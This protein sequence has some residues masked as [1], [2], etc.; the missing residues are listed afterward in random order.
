MLRSGQIVFLCVLALL[1]LGVVMV[2][3]AG[4][5]VDPREAV[6]VKSIL[7]SRSTVYMALAVAAMT[8]CALLPIRRLVPRAW[9]VSPDAVRLDTSP[10]GLLV[11]GEFARNLL[12]TIRELWPMWVIVCALLAVLAMVYIPG[13]GRTVNGSSRWISL[14]APGLESIQP[15]EL[16]KWALVGVLAWYGA[17]NM[18]RL[19]KFWRGLLPGLCAAGAVAAF[20]VVED[21]GTGVLLGLVTC[22]VLVAAGARVWHLAV[23]APLPLTMVGLAISTSQYRRERLLAFMNPYADADGIGYHMIQSMVAVANGNLAGRGLG[24][25]L[26]KFGY[27]P[28]DRTDFLFAVI[29]EELGVA[30]A[31]MV[32]ALYGLMFYACW[33]IIRREQA[34]MLKL[35]GLGVLATVAIQAIIN[36]A[37]VTGL[38]PT[39]GIALPLLSSGGTGWILTAASLG[40]IVAMDRTQDGWAAPVVVDS[41][42]AD[43]AAEPETDT[44]EVEPAPIDAPSD[45]TRFAPPAL[46]AAAIPVALAAA[47]ADDDRLSRMA[48]DDDGEQ[49]LL[50]VPSTETAPQRADDDDDNDDEWTESDD[51]RVL[52]AN[53]GDADTS[54][55]GHDGGPAGA[56]SEI[57][58]RAADSHALNERAG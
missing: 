2:N 11:S 13:L 34:A 17:T 37:V 25:G 23:L 31:F 28:E 43:L 16:A 45:E 38:G 6:T 3:S 1:T 18:H 24:H 53:D 10:D 55:A 51:G 54:E 41:V 47:V 50:F 39:K 49:G 42:S 58:V 33:T 52:S 4:M 29:C 26:Q 15:S 7:L 36:L 40:L 8:C 44:A 48:L 12:R 57:V 27:L 35:L 32:V 9:L 30:G 19:H 20:I 14:G 46:A 21:L 22:V 56:E 5:S